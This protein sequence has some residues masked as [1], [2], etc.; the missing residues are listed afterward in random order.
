[1]KFLNLKNIALGALG[2]TM[3]SC[4]SFL[5]TP[6]LDAIPDD[7]WWKDK[8]QVQMMVDNTYSYLPNETEIVIWDCLSDNGYHRHGTKNIANGTFT[9]TDGIVGNCW[10]YGA[11][12]RINYVLE[13]LEKAKDVITEEEYLGFK[14]E[15]QF[16]RAYTYYNML[17]RFGD[18]PLI[19]KTLTVAESRETSRQPRAE[20]LNF[21]LDELENKVLPH[22]QNADKVQAGR[23]NKQVVDA[24][25]ARV[26]LYEKNYEKAVK[27]ADAVINS[28]Q[29]ELF[30]DYEELFKPQA[31]KTNKEVIFERQYSSPLYVH[32]LNRTLSYSGSIYSG[33]SEIMLLQD[34]V[35]EY[36]CINGH[37]VSKCE[38]LG[39]E[40]HQRRLD[41]TTENHRGEYDYRDPR[42]NGT[43]IWPFKEWKV[44]DEV[45]CTF[46]VDDKSSRD[47]V[48]KE[49]HHTGFLVNK[50][51]DLKGEFLDR[52]RGE[53]NLTI[54]RYADVLLMKAEALIEMNKDFS[55]AV[56]LINQV[57]ARVQMPAISVSNQADLREK[58][59]HE[60]R[61]ELAFEGLR[62]DDIIRW[63]IGDQTLGTKAGKP[64][65]GARL[66]L[67]GEPGNPMPNKFMEKRF[68]D[69]KMY[70]FPVP[71]GAIDNNANLTQNPGW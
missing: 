19:K 38:E 15:A 70:L 64:T 50:W 10:K 56:D 60:R 59:R 34:L 1:M 63:K 26:Y 35:D 5:T 42:L 54:I 53:K 51:L 68:W 11:I 24:F 43:V 71:Q 46:G 44:G 17:F 23:V 13:G 45:R 12:A 62:R 37:D 69:D 33:W 27:H 4:D 36:E 7:S 9:T 67:L 18:V 55:V 29:Y 28:N 22:V 58:V 57:R 41:E 66:K 8:L 61:V 40:Y 31:D 39:C 20:V 3:F 6:P 47:N 21:V 30:N 16:I 2:L 49:T 25:L 48:I 52:T 14:A 65:Y 32:T